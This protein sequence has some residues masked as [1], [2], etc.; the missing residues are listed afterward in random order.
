MSSIRVNNEPE[1]EEEQGIFERRTSRRS[2]VK[3]GLMAGAAAAIAPGALAACGGDDNG[4]GNGEAADADWD[5]QTIRV[6]GLG[7]DLIDPIAE[8]AQA[9]TGFTYEFTVRDTPTTTALSIT[10]PNDFDILSGYAHQIPQIMEA[11]VMQWIPTDRVT[12]WD[13]VVPLLTEGK[14]RP[15]CTT[16]QGDALYRMLPVDPDDDSRLTGGTPFEAAEQEEVPQSDTITGVTGNFNVDSLGYNRDAPEFGGQ[17]V[18][19][20]AELFRPE[21]A[22]KVAVINDPQIG[23]VDCA[24][25]LE[26]AGMMTFGNKAVMTPDEIDEMMKILTDLK[27]NGHF[28][29]FWSTFDESVN[30]MAGGEVVLESMWSPAVALLAEQGQNVGFMDPVEGFRGWGGVQ[31]VFDHVGQGAKFDAC[32]DYLNWWLSGEPGAIMARQGYYNPVPQNVRE[33][34]EPAEWDYWYGGQPAATNL[35]GP[36][37]EQQLPKGDVREG[38]SFEERICRYN[39]WNTQQPEAELLTQ[40]WNDF[41]AA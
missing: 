13:N 37:G 14:L 24:M 18:T 19:S 9:A 34:L 25:G 15:E 40:R 33:F 2:V 7:V 30:L 6:V 8:A 3:G 17:P 28:R 5:G 39:T 23:S 41:V 32:M 10:Q 31:M 27:R 1:P 11:G 36:S 16:G 21:L 12:E 22:G 26:A 35:V 4:D 38:G 20:W 29:A